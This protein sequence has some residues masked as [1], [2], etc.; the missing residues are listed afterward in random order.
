MVS[1][2]CNGL[3]VLHDL[4]GIS[5]D[6][7]TQLTQVTR[8]ALVLGIQSIQRDVDVSNLIA[9]PSK[10][11]VDPGRISLDTVDLALLVGNRLL[12]TRSGLLN[13]A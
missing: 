1:F 13:F 7:I 3:F 10:R 5:R 4:C 9:L 12:S 6:F 8:H 2:E 11:F